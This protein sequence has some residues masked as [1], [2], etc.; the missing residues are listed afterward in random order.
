MKW[1]DKQ[2][3]TCLDLPNR[4]ILLQFLDSLP[5]MPSEPCVSH[6]TW[7]TWTTCYNFIV[8][9]PVP[10]ARS[11]LSLQQTATI[12]NLEIKSGFLLKKEKKNDRSVRFF[13]TEMGESPVMSSDMCVC[14]SVCDCKPDRLLHLVP[15]RGHASS[16]TQS[17]YTCPS[18]WLLDAVLS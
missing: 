18:H 1:D 17:A 16:L 13:S 2:T 8:L 5:V 3:F 12:C 10:T 15:T 4:N 7:E 14:V 11:H 6:N 9:V